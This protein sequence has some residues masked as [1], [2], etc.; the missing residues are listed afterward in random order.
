[1][2]TSKPGLTRYMAPELLNPPQFDLTHSDPSKDSDVY[3][4]AMTAYEVHSSYH[5]PWFTLL[6]NATLYIGPF[7]NLAVRW[8]GGGPHGLK[9]CIW[10]PTASPE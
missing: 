10:Q 2:T 5:T 6:T 8:C 1:M 4:F 7:G 9:H 3:S